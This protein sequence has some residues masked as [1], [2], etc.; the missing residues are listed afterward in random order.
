MQT[1]LK[2]PIK[3]QT[4]VMSI[5]AWR[6]LGGVCDLRCTIMKPTHSSH[7]E[8]RRLQLHEQQAERQRKDP[9]QKCLVFAKR[10]HE[11]TA[12]ASISVAFIR[13]SSEFF[14]A[15]GRLLDNN[16]FPLREI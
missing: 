15:L 11:K 16:S 7:H 14:D 9:V 1:I 6:W 3:P 10:A 13:F 4:I 8:W 12:E 5:D 2:E